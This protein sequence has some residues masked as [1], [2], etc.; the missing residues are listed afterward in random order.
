VNSATGNAAWHL[1]LA[2]G[3]SALGV[4]WKNAWLQFEEALDD[5]PV[6]GLRGDRD[7]WK[8]HQLLTKLLPATRGML[9]AKVC[10]DL[11]AAIKDETSG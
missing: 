10:H 1:A 4:N 9:R 3:L 11:P 8:G 7:V 5:Q 2:V 6:L